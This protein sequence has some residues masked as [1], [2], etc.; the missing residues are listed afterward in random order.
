MCF[1]A[2]LQTYP[3]LSPV[4]VCEPC[5][6][7][8]KACLAWLGSFVWAPFTIHKPPPTSI[9]FP[10]DSSTQHGALFH[11]PHTHLAF[12]MWIFFIWIFIRPTGQRFGW[13]GGFSLFYRIFGV[14]M[15]AKPWFFF[16]WLKIRLSD[17]ARSEQ[18]EKCKC[19]KPCRCCQS[20]R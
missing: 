14:T 12:L 9:L 3:I 20:V 6:A 15:I 18:L 5:V 4:E 8:L 10:S 11:N 16:F 13:H 19:K 17:G 2:E 7:A 1:R